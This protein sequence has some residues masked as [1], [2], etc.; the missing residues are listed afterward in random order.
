MGSREYLG[1][2]GDPLLKYSSCLDGGGNWFW[3]L[4]TYLPVL[5]HGSREGS[6]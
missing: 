4:G 2:L 1:G 3:G 6:H 5:V